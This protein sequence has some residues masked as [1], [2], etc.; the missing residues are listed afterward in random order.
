[1]IGNRPKARSSSASSLPHKL[2]SSTPRSV[3]GQVPSWPLSSMIH[4]VRASGPHPI[5]T[6]KCQNSPSFLP[7]TLI[8]SPKFLPF[9]ALCHSSTPP[10]SRARIRR[11][12]VHSPIYP[13]FGR[14]SLCVRACVRGGDGDGDVP[15]FHRPSQS[16][17]LSDLLPIRVYT[18]THIYVCVQNLL[19]DWVFPQ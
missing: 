16:D 15:R 9:M 1:M 7:L 19:I 14:G 3:F 10:P 13:P 6:T 8:P 17:Y 5:S 2:A 18:H 12:S 11:R 4:K